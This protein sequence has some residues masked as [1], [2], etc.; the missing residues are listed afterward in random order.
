MNMTFSPD[1]R[2]IATS[3]QNGEI[4]LWD[5]D[6]LRALIDLTRPESE[7]L[8]VLTFT[9][10]GDRLFALARDGKGIGIVQWDGSPRGGG[11]RK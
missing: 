7:G 8:H 9:P 5:A 10:E 11:D 4:I 2:R 3:Q 6:S 1:G